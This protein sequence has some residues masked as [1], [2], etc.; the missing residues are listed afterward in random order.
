M[1][2]LE[3]CDRRVLLDEQCLLKYRQVAGSPSLQVFCDP[4]NRARVSERCE[5]LDPSRGLL[6]SRSGT[7]AASAS[8]CGAS[9]VNVFCHPTQIML[10][11]HGRKLRNIKPVYEVKQSEESN[12]IGFLPYDM[13]FQSIKHADGQVLAPSQNGQ[14]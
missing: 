9:D 10:R 11:T 14:S 6:F 13:D 4:G 8:K 12:S 1:C 2:A 5:E 7:I 3:G